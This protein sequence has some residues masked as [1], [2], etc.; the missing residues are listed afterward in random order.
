MKLDEIQNKKYNLSH[1]DTISFF[2]CCEDVLFR[3]LRACGVE[4]RRDTSFYLA[5]PL[6]AAE[7]PVQEALSQCRQSVE[8][9]HSFLGVWGNAEKRGEF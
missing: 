8:A 9:V 5:A 6:D 2:H 4:L 1:T 7:L 3:V